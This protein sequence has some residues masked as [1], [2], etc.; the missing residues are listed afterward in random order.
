MSLSYAIRFLANSLIVAANGWGLSYSFD[1][2]CY[3]MSHGIC[4]LQS[5]IV[6]FPSPLPYEDTKSSFPPNDFEHG[7]LLVFKFWK[8][9]VNPF[10]W[11]I[12]IALIFFN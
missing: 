4:C 7:L 9:F 6:T 10:L 2:S 12:T 11:S 5:Y 1:S 8:H 3:I